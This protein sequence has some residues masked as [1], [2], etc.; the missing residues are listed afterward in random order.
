MLPIAHDD[1]VPDAA[2]PEASSAQLAGA[3]VLSEATAEPCPPSPA[4][5]TASVVPMSDVAAM[6]ASPEPPLSPSE[7]HAQEEAEEAATQSLP[8]PFD[9]LGAMEALTVAPK[10]TEAEAAAA[11]A[12][13]G[14]A[15]PSHEASPLHGKSL[16]SLRRQVSAAIVA[17]RGRWL[18]LGGAAPVAGAN[19]ST[20]PASSRAK[21]PSSIFVPSSSVS[22]SFG[23]SDEEDEEAPA[24]V[25]G[26]HTRFLD[27]PDGGVAPVVAGP[28]RL[29][30]L[31]TPVGVHTRFLA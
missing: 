29:K 13:P 2:K 19:A 26:R 28:E 16:A 23:A 1:V 20:A 18:M 21:L 5:P 17:R 24:P 3:P 15:A 11:S 9:L 8:P 7:V 6:L 27:A 31:P 14:P 25:C 10:E 4:A 12:A 30:G 22:A